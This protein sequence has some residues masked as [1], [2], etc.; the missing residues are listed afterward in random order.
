MKQKNYPKKKSFRKHG[1][2]ATVMLITVLLLLA[3][4]GSVY[5]LNKDN[6]SSAPE[7]TSG[8]KEDGI[9]FSPPTEEELN[10]TEQHKKE[11]GDQAKDNTGTASN[12][13]SSNKAKPIITS[14]G[15]YNGS[16]EVGSRVPGIF[17]SSGTC[18]LRLSKGGKTVSKSQK[19]TPNVSEMSCGFIS[20]PTSKLSAGNWSAAVSY[21][22]N[23]YSGQSNSV[24]VRVQ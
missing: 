11:L 10:A 1:K 6:N 13:D 12:S 18:T 8:E 9:N 23:K 4:A 7:E 20:I 21:K 24:T 16:V 15:V 19:A 5:F 2:L 3:G 17:E 22:S 14:S